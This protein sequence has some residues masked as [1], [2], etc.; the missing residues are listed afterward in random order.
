MV[1]ISESELEILKIIWQKGKASSTEVVEALQGDKWNENT[2]RTFINRLANKG[3]IGVCE[4]QGKKAI[5]RS[6]IERDEYLHER[7]KKF[8][9]QYYDGSVVSLLE[10]LMQNEPE[11]AEE[12]KK[13]IQNPK[14]LK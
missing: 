13:C 12:I 2:I 5:Y 9:E 14:T 6:N 8:V 10:N 7:S 1:K 4:M 11:Y 3:V